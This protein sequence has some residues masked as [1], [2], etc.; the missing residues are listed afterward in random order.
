MGDLRQDAA[1]QS[2]CGPGAAA[3]LLLRE[4]IEQRTSRLASDV[5]NQQCYTLQLK[6]LGPTEWATRISTSLA[7]ASPSTD[8]VT[9]P[10]ADAAS[11]KQS[12]KLP[13]PGLPARA[14]R[15]CWIF[16]TM[17]LCCYAD[18]DDEVR[19]VQNHEHDVKSG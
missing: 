15:D 7:A 5:S 4:I 12:S 10:I 17:V 16:R 9:S 6:Y 18:V 8:L 2:Q 11:T 3:L 13:P 14:R 19:W 1:G